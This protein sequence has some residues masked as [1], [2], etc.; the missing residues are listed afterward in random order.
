[1]PDSQLHPTAGAPTSP[2]VAWWACGKPPTPQPQRRPGSPH[3]K[4]QTPQPPQRPD[5]SAFNLT[6]RYPSIPLW[7]RPCCCRKTRH[8]ARSPCLPHRLGRARRSALAEKGISR[9]APTNWV[10]K[11]ITPPPRVAPWGILARSDFRIFLRNAFFPQARQS[12]RKARTLFLEPM[13]S[14]AWFNELQRHRTNARDLS[15]AFR[16]M[17]RVLFCGVPDE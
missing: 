9:G 13:R 11:T 7:A 2:T 16:K 5:E 4:K 8:S 17:V 6:G 3:S 1:M 15:S 12:S 10:C 14:V